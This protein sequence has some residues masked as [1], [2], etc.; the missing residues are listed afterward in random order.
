M[1]PAAF[2]LKWTDG[3][4]ICGSTVVI[5]AHSSATKYVTLIQK[6]HLAS[7]QVSISRLLSL[8]Y[9]RYDFPLSSSH[10][11]I[12]SLASD[13]VSKRLPISTIAAWSILRFHSLSTMHINRRR[14]VLTRLVGPWWASGW[15]FSRVENK[16]DKSV[17]LKSLDGTAVNHRKFVPSTIL[18]A[19]FNM[20]LPASLAHPYLPLNLSCSKHSRVLVLLHR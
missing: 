8:L 2:F 3:E 17:I 19:Q 10:R 6:V 11:L 18:S 9:T 13:K 1:L 12:T 4:Q 7:L 5:S 15:Q 14:R 16:G 20:M